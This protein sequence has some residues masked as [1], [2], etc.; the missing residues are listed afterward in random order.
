MS[1][2]P[3][4]TD[5]PKSPAASSESYDI[6]KPSWV[7]IQT[8]L[9]GTE[10]MRAAGML[11]LP[12]HDNESVLAYQ[13]RLNACTLFNLTDITLNAWVGR[14]FSDQLKAS[15]ENPIPPALEEFNDDIDLQG[16]DFSV[17]ARNWFKDGLAKA[18]SHVLVDMPQPVD[19][20]ATEGRARTLADDRQEGLRPYWIHIRPENLFFADAATI[21]GKEV[22]REIRIWEV[23]KFRQGF[24]ERAIP[25]IRRLFLVLTEDGSFQVAVEI[26]REREKFRNEE[27]QWELVQSSIMQIDEIPLVTFYADRDGFHL[28]KPP[29]VDLADLNVAHWQS[30]SDQRAVITVARFPILAL[31]GGVDDDNVLTIG[32]NSWL[33]SPDPQSKFYYVEHSGDAIEAGRKDLEALEFQMSEYG[34]EFLKKRPGNVTAT[35]R[36]LDSAEAN[37]PLQDAT[38]RFMD[39]MKRAL[40]LTAKWLGLED[41]GEVELPTDFGP[42]EFTAPEMA[43]LNQAR[44]QRDLSLE[45]YLAEL[46]RRG[47]LN[48]DIDIDEEIGRLEKEALQMT[49]SSPAE[50]EETEDEDEEDE[51]EKESGAPEG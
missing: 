44:K 14:P 12:Q 40:D 34:A 36:A 19:T 4:T 8:V 39:A 29:I 22:L 37:S 13:E 47:A 30:T 5:N 27:E 45:T 6:M 46:Q 25:Q 24:A 11:Y 15:Q 26:Y 3:D 43:T 28:G 20:E 7:K 1:R 50:F 23:H 49:A 17:F 2:L 48:E 38:I 35:A 32:P 51:K 31:S 42:E 33:Y 21:D 10:A 41:G 18:I 16:T 9:D